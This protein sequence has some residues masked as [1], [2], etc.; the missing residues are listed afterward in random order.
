MRRRKQQRRKQ[1]NRV[2]PAWHCLRWSQLGISGVVV[3][4]LCMLTVGYHVVDLFVH[5]NIWNTI[6]VLVMIGFTG[7]VAFANIKWAQAKRSRRR[8][9]TANSRKAA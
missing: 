5:P 9:R 6:V 1:P 7:F 4:S 2:R 8:S 3:L